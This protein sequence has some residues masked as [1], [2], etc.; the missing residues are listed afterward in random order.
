M[1]EDLL[2]NAIGDQPNTSTRPED[3]PEKFW[4][5]EAGQLRVDALLKSYREL[6]R[7]LSQRMA[8]PSP[9]A[10]EEEVQRFRRSLGIPDSPGEYQITPKHDLCCVDDAVNKR[11]HDAGFTPAQAQLV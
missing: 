1:P 11:L 2:A 6:E 9:D 4:D 8:P 7:R 10:P 5:Q 3:V